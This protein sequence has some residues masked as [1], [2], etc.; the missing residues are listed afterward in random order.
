V[1][2]A[3]NFR[4]PAA[5]ARFFLVMLVGLSADLVTK[6]VAYAKLVEVAYVTREGRSEVVSKQPNPVVIP[7]VVE[8]HVTNNHGAVFG[9]GQGK[10]PFFIAVSLVAIVFLT[11]L[12]SQSVG[13]KLYQIILGLLLAGVLGNMYDRAVYGYVRDMIYGLPGWA[14]PGDWTLSFLNYPA[15][16]ERLVFPWIF[17]IADMMLCTGVFSMIVYSFFQKPVPKPEPASAA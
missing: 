16:P 6:Y 5:L 12:F 8:L 11:Y 2:S 10:R 3:S 15:R 14:W 9:M 4:S 1:K 17:N 7:H 13:Q